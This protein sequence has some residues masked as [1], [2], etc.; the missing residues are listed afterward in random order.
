MSTGLWMYNLFHFIFVFLGR[1]GYLRF[2]WNNLFA[3]FSANLIEVHLHPH[4]PV[5]FPSVMYHG[6]FTT[7]LER[8]VSK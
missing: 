4:L 5:A 8:Q 2:K 6:L 1:G 3:M 7:G